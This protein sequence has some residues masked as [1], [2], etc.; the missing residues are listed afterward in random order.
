MKIAIVGG[1]GSNVPLIIDAIIRNNAFDL[2]EEIVLYDIDAKNLKIIYDFCRFLCKNKPIKLYKSLILEEALINSE[3]IINYFRSGNLEQRKED[4][5]A[6]MRNG[7]LG[8]ET[9]GAMGILSAYRQLSVIEK[10]CVAASRICPKALLM[11]I[12][13]PVNV[14]TKA[15][16]D[17]NIKS[18]GICEL[19]WN[20]YLAI[21]KIENLEINEKS[22]EITIN[23]IGINHI[24][25]ITSINS[26][27]RN[28]IKPFIKNRIDKYY[29]LSK[30]QN[31]SRA[32]SLPSK[33]NDI[34][35][36]PYLFYYYN[37]IE[38]F[39]LENQMP[40]RSMKAIEIRNKLM[41]CYTKK[42]FNNWIEISNGRGGFLVGESLVNFLKSYFN[43]CDTFFPGINLRNNGIIPFLENDD[44]I[45]LSVICKNKTVHPVAQDFSL[46]VTVKGLI[47]P[48]TLSNNIII[49]A[50]SQQKP[51]MLLDAMS[52]HPLVGDIDKSKK[53]LK[54]LVSTL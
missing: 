11:N 16:L 43:K 54:D 28:I 20:S 50:Y 49:E 21:K 30:P 7:L 48:I 52:I 53:L 10:V 23:W 44:I 12:S 29:Q 18:F 22:S 14:L 36:A 1:A 8:Q 45:E 35:P 32:P 26:E 25:W 34:I 40:L 33:Q 51:Q 37:R 27:K 24:S 9:Q 6:C 47:M 13:N 5:L 41:D 15:S 39:E 3:I 17:F 2:F 42:D 31:V 46:P 4:Q 38:A 19:P